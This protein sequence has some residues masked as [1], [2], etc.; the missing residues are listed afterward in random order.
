MNFNIL[1]L[2]LIVLSFTLIETTIPLDFVENF[3]LFRHFNYFNL[4]DQF[5]CNQLHLH[6]LLYL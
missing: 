4:I 5:K 3:Q 1:T 2:I 6:Q